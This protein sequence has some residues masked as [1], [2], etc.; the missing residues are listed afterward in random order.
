[1]QGIRGEGGEVSAAAYSTGSGP[2]KLC[3]SDLETH[4][5]NYVILAFLELNGN[6]KVITYKN[7][8]LIHVYLHWDP[9]LLPSH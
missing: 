4:E 6:K 3:D 8:V 9:S 1:M 5:I 2:N 7:D